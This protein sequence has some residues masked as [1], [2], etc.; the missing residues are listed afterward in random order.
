MVKKKL[1]HPA[2]G[3]VL[4]GE[5][6]DLLPKAEAK[7]EDRCVCGKPG[8]VYSGLH[9][10]KFC[11][12][13]CIEFVM[14]GEKAIAEIK[15]TADGQ[16]AYFKQGD[17]SFEVDL[18]DLNKVVDGNRQGTPVDKLMDSQIL[19]LAEINGLPVTPFSRDLLRPVL[20]GVLQN[21]WYRDIEKRELSEHLLQNQS[22][23]VAWYHRALRDYKEPE[24][25]KA[26]KAPAGLG[27]TTAARAVAKGVSLTQKITLKKMPKEG[28]IPKQAFVMM[29]ILKEKGGVLTAA[30]LQNAMAGKVV[31]KQPMSIIWNFYRNKLVQEK[32]VEVS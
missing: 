25:K 13:R 15:V 9:N 3:D 32:F 23:R 2:K 30:D 6:L 8:Q 26:S 28:D 17:I 27:G 1:K 10:R 16:K 7:T 29:T 24:E 19:S 12:E 20:I 5:Q 31:S 21:T 11:S 22:N 4:K 14:K 18:K